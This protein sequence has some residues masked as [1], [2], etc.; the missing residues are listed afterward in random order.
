MVWRGI[1]RLTAL[2]VCSVASFPLSAEPLVQIAQAE[3]GAES[4]PGAAAESPAPTET[5]PG[6]TP[7]PSPEAPAPAAQAPEVSPP[8]QSDAELETITVKPSHQAPRTTTVARKSVPG[9][10]PGTPGGESSGAP[11][12]G[13]APML[14]LPESAWGPVEGFVATRSATGIKT[15]TPIVEIPQSISV[16]TPDRMEQLGAN[17]LSEALNYTAGVRSDIYG[18]DSRYDWL[19]IRGFDAYFPGF[20]FDGLFARNN[21]TWAAWK[22]EPYGAE[23]IEVLKGPS[24][25]LYGQMNPGGLVNIVT[26]RPKP[27]P[28]GEVGIQF[29]NFDRIQPYFDIGGNVTEDGKVLYRFTGLGLSTDTQ[30][31]YVTDDRFYLAPAVTFRP[32]SDTTLT[33]LGYYL[34]EKTGVTSNFLPAEGSLLP[35]PNGRVRRSFFSGEPNNDHFDTEQ[36]AVS[37]FLEHRF[38]DVWRVRQNARYGRIDLDFTS[39]YGT[40][41][42]P[43]DPTK[44]LFLRNAFF[45][46]ESV[47]QFVI[48][49]QAQANFS[50]GAIDHTLLV[51]VDYQNNQFKQ[52]SGDGPASPIDMYKPVYGEFVDTPPLFADADITLAQTGTYIQDQAKL[53]DRFILV[54]GG[55]YDWARNVV[56]DHLWGADT[57]QNDE[58]FTW[59]VGGVYLGPYGISPYAS[60]ATSFLPI[61][62]F[63][64]FTG[65]P[66]DPETGQQYEAGIKFQPEGRKTLMTFSAFDIRRQNYLTYDNLFNPRQTG[67]ILSRGLEFETVAELWKGVDFIAAY[68]WLPEFTIT[69]TSDPLELNKREPITPEHMASA[70]LHYRFGHGRFKGFGFGGGVRYIGET[71][72]DSINSELMIVP[73]I[74]LFDAVIDYEAGGWRFAVN[75]TNLEDETYVASCWDTCYYGGARTIVGTIRRRW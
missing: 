41:L 21:N 19:S 33:V 72:G 43:T 17:T 59:R 44:R 28:F 67:E 10:S 20:Y 68:T 61:S 18:T 55:R 40:G 39:L 8:K 27:E 69:E 9:A 26:K 11:T 54:A 56:D 73:A 71:F 36:W 1:G 57:E 5:P 31:D 16:I 64:P 50:T 29:G 30:V 34:D 4:A 47:G 37:Y 70:W 53:F 32:S 13:S 46:D 23:R 75:A 6:D 66:F 42:D 51:G 22:V 58:G 48:D 74:T 38:N 12:T 35:N 52:L 49:N 25:V 45:S 15:D 62:G 14:N 7:Q 60:Y 63:D 65:S 24:S 3:Q 2:I